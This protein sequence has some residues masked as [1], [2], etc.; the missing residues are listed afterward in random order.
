MKKLLLVA[1]ILIASASAFSWQRGHAEILR[2]RNAALHAQLSQNEQI[3]AQL[4]RQNDTVRRRV[5][6]REAALLALET[7]LAAA[8]KPSTISSGATP[9]SGANRW[10]DDV[11]FVRLSKANLTSLS[12][13]IIARDGANGCH[14]AAPAATLLGLTAEELSAVNEAIR[15]LCEQYLALELARA[16]QIPKY[17]RARD[18]VETVFAIPRLESEGA[19]LKKTFSEA[20]VGAIGQSRTDLILHYGRDVFW[21]QLAGFGENTKTMNL[22]AKLDEQ[23]QE[24]V[25]AHVDFHGRQNGGYT[26]TLTRGD[27]PNAALAR[28]LWER[29]Q[30][31]GK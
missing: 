29:A 22:M 21:R 20:L 3:A 17:E 19:E 30:A 6:E 16:P 7:R 31:I 26:F 28:A 1:L 8:V 25:W 13:G 14:L 9:E 23:G 12:V 5:E 27:D 24:Y 11:P 15:N 18:G 2:Q 4:Q 10:R